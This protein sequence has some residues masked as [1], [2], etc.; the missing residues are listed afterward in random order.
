MP[1]RRFSQRYFIFFLYFVLSLA[2]RQNEIQMNLCKLFFRRAG[3]KNNL[4][5][6]EKYLGA[7]G[8]T[9]S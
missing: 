8:L 6:K 7:A 3:R 9:A 5:E 4:H 1:K 2:E